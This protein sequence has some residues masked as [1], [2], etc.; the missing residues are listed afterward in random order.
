LGF[1][2]L[3]GPLYEALAAD[4]GFFVQVMEVTW[5]RSGDQ[6]D[7][8][9]G[10]V[11]ERDASATAA[12]AQQAENGRRLLTSFDRLPG[13]D[14]QGTANV[15]V[16]KNWTARVLQLA[17]EA[18][19]REVA[20]MLVGQILANAPTDTDGTW[21]CQPVRDLL[22]NLQSGLVERSLTEALYNRRGLTTRS[23]E[24]GEQQE[25][26]LAEKCRAQAGTLADAGPRIAAVRRDLATMYDTDA[27][28]E[29]SKAQRFRQGQLR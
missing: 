16:L 14:A 9:D 25:L 6:A 19:L 5:P 11:P 10:A 27:P 23:P 13:T 15:D 12:R 7:E 17:G 20:E 4:P 18:G 22:E 29:E 21:P 2:S 3:I 1:E 24:E 28:Q 26:A 8:D